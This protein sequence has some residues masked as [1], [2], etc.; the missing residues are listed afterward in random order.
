MLFSRGL[1]LFIVQKFLSRL[2]PRLIYAMLF[3]LAFQVNSSMGSSK[4]LLPV[5]S[6]ELISWFT[7]F[8]NLVIYFKALHNL[9]LLLSLYLFPH[10]GLLFCCYNACHILPGLGARALHFFQ[11]LHWD[12]SVSIIKIDLQ[13]KA[14]VDKVCVQYRLNIEVLKL[15]LSSLLVYELQ[16]VITLDCIIHP[17]SWMNIQ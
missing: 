16:L 4:M 1:W 13:Q 2:D 12:C 9:L 11:T 14:P 8:Y 6:L 5:S 3:L 15:N 17:I 7:W 10:H